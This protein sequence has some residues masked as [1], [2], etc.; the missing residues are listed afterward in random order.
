MLIISTLKSTEKLWNE[1]SRWVSWFVK[2]DTL[3]LADALESF[4][5]KFIQM[6]ELDPT[7]FFSAAALTW[8][9]AYKK[10]NIELLTDIDILLIVKKGI[11]GRICHAIHRYKKANNICMKEYNK[12]N[13]SSYIMYLDA[14]K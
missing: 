8:Q 13:E 9:R 7:W 3:L 6:Y 14:N 5:N 12:D 1:K 2:S 10:Q 4:Y 11:R